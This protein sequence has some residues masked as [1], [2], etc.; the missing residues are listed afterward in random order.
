MR[1]FPLAFLVFCGAASASRLPVE[2]RMPS[3]ASASWVNSPPLTNQGLGGKVVL[4][5][6][7]IPNVGRF[8]V[9]ADPA[10]ATFAIIKLTLD[11]KKH[12]ASDKPAAAPAKAQKKK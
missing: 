6:M 9:L 2:G 5:P 11:H 7:D 12:T 8:S 10:G 3:L 1:L 4:P